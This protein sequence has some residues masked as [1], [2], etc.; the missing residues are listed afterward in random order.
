MEV[1]LAGCAG[2]AVRPTHRTTQ[3]DQRALR[4]LGAGCDAFLVPAVGEFAHLHPG[5]DGSLH[6]ALPRALAAEAIAR[7]WA[8][9]HPL[10]GIRLTPGMVLI[11][12]PRTPDELDV[13]SSR[14]LQ[15]SSSRGE[16][17]P[18]DGGEVAG[19]LGRAPGSVVE[20][21]KAAVVGEQPFPHP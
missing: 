18:V 2:A 14:G 1:R 16:P 9:A 19:E 10:A 17:A 8:V 13:V 11:Y 12:G 3:G 15:A 5:Y 7:G 6:L 4:D 21:G 20:A